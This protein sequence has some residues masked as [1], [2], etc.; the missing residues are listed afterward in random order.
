MHVLFVE[1]AFPK[2][3][4]VGVFNLELARTAARNRRYAEAV[5]FALGAVGVD[6]RSWQSYVVLGVTA[7]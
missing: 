4:L 2:N 1:P 7:C 5:Q 6:R 3:Q